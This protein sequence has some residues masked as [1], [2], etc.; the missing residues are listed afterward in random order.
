MNTKILGTGVYLPKTS[1]TAKQAHEK[2]SQSLQREI[3]L[4]HF[5][6]EHRYV[7]ENETISEMAAK[8]LA[9]ALECS[10]LKA[11][12]LDLIIF[13]GAMPEQPIPSTA[14]LLHHKMGLGD[15]GI[16]CFDIN[17]T[18]TSFL[19]ALDVAAS[20][21]ITK[22]YHR[23]A[24]VNSEVGSKGINW[25]ELEVASIIADGASAVIVEADDQG[26]SKIMASLSNTYSI[27]AKLCEIKAGGSRFNIVTPPDDPDDYLF[28]MEGRGIYKLASRYL[29]Q[30]VSQ[31]LKK[32]NL[33]LSE[34]DWVVPHQASP[35]A[36][37]Q[38][39]RKLDFADEKLINII[40]THG[41]QVSASLPIALDNC[42]KEKAKRGDK[43]LLI[44]TGAGISI[45]GSILVY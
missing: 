32:A 40:Q 31:L 30:F 3:G 27:G 33:Q 38:L 35:T 15:S 16:P 14:V 39:S 13:G 21:L 28:R 19:T 36:I 1:L 20:F 12:D 42:L 10:R 45:S 29:P 6:V 17:S 8:A 43:I 9:S 26:P 41:N 24:L 37:L 34:I 7:S 5:D 23:I 2:S 22:R 44:G 25:K 18:C 4:E 11:T